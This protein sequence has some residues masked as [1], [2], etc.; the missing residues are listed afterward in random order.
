M[1]TALS[2]L[3]VFAQEDEKELQTPHAECAFLGPQGQRFRKGPDH[4][5]SR[6]TVEVAARLPLS[7]KEG[8][9]RAAA[10]PNN[11]IDRHLSQIWKDAGVTPAA[12]TSDYEFIRRV[13]LDLTGRVPAVQRVQQFVA[14]SSADKRTAL[15]DELIGSEAFTDKWTMYF[16]DL[17]GNTLRTT[18]VVRY[19]DGRNAFHGWIRTAVA[20][21]KPFDRIATELI[22]AAGDNS[23]ERGDLNW[24]VGGFV[25]GGPVQDIW[26]QMAVN[27]A[28]TFLGLG[29][30]NCVACHDG[31]RHLDTLSLWG[32][33]ATR[34]QA[35]QLS[36]FFAGTDL[37]R[38]RVGERATPYY[39]SVRPA[40]AAARREYNLNTTTGNRPER[41][42]VGTMRV[43]APEYPFSGATPA[44][45]ESRRVALARFITTDAQFA[46]SAVNRI[47]K[48][49]M[50]KAFVEPVDQFDPARLDPDNPPPDPWK[51]QP[52]QPWLL[53][54]LA[55]EFSGAMKFDLRKLM[56]TIVLSEAYQLSSRYEG[57]W[58]PAWE[59]TYARKL[60][61][62]LMAEE[63]HDAV[64][65]TSNVP[66]N[67]N[68]AGLGRLSWAMQLP[69][70]VNV[71]GGAATSWLDS[72]M[73]GNRDD[74]DRRRE[75]SVLQA[76]NLMND[77]FVITRTRAGGAAS[78]NLA[79]QA[80][81][82]GSDDQLV[83]LLF[84]T[85]LS[86]NPTDAERAAALT[87]IRSGNRQQ[88]TEDL[89]WALYNK[90]DFFFNY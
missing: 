57:E 24:I 89:L 52:N 90:V 87:A 64:V 34:L 43:V 14:D 1:F 25:T 46:R 40:A 18:Q 61:R 53:N 3:Y 58:N 42:A 10:D 28:E 4:T 76:L 78:A 88:K 44:S 5:F 26:D 79:R 80:L 54:A 2:G 23:Y 16:G 6:Q 21:N 20:E 27:T 82:Q 86:R 32:K 33:S 83:N 22:S 9:S 81:N 60:V 65:Q 17:L 41:R 48:E 73:R 62:R 55:Q 85:V 36:A 50:V 49:F 71:P 66:V 29:H 13:T 7:S 67:Y 47:W 63:I 51:L 35:Y 72:F 69:D 56:R 8:A 45:G 70:V 11:V 75:G 84:L 59:D 30:L 15:V 68:V 39:W 19:A 37:V 31:R 74:E 38:T 12:R 77:T